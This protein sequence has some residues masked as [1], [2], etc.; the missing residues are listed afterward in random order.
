[1]RALLLPALL[2]LVVAGC[3]RFP[4]AGTQWRDLPPLGAEHAPQPQSLS[5]ALEAKEA[6]DAP[7]AA[8][9]KSDLATKA[10]LERF[11]VA[12]CRKLY[13]EGL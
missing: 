5:A 11:Y 2:L 3:A 9:M 12:L 10:D 6:R 4:D 7:A 8:A 13:D 1:M